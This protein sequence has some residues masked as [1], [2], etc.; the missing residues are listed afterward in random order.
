MGAILQ[1]LNYP[2]NL[3]NALLCRCI[4]FG[5]REA[6]SCPSTTGQRLVSIAIPFFC[7][8]DAMPIIAIS[9]HAQAYVREGEIKQQ[10][11]KWILRFVC[12][13]TRVHFIHQL[14]FDRCRTFPA[15]LARTITKAARISISRIYQEGFSALKAGYF[16]PFD[17][18]KLTDISIF[19]STFMATELSIALFHKTLR[20]AERFATLLAD[21]ISHWTTVPFLFRARFFLARLVVA[22]E[23]TIASSF[24]AL[25][26]YAEL[27]A[28]TFTDCKRCWT[29]AFHRTKTC[30]SARCIR[31]LLTTSLTSA[32][33]SR[34]CH[35]SRKDGLVRR[36]GSSARETE[37]SERF[38]RP[39]L[40][41]HYYT[42][43]CPN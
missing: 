1:I 37:R 38:M 9:F 40:A 33:L 6:Q 41:R 8:G 30:F 42:A 5:F 43:L 16:N 34:H 11:I 23:R 24:S 26:F 14:R 35:L 13:T 29:T 19:C 3:I 36:V 39:F 21:T 28:A 15:L 17:G 25:R 12:N 4:D 31:E 2:R 27:L 7:A 32:N 18:S 20:V 10:R 22:I